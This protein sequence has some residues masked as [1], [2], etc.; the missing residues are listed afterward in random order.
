M[1][2]AL[3]QT[4]RDTS[5]LKHLLILTALNQS[6]ELFKLTEVVDL[7]T[8]VKNICLTSDYSRLQEGIESFNEHAEHLQE[9]C[10][11]LTHVAPTEHL[12]SMTKSSES[13]LC[14]YWPQV[15]NACQALCFHPMSKH[16]LTN[17]EVL[18]NLWLSLYNEIHHLSCA[19]SDLLNVSVS[20]I[21]SSSSLASLVPGR[22]S[23]FGHHPPLPP[24]S[25]ITHIPSS[26]PYHAKRVTIQDTPSEDPFGSIPSTGHA[27]P[28]HHHPL[29]PSPLVSS[30]GSYMRPPPSHLPPSSSYPLEQ[31]SVEEL[32]GETAAGGG[33][34]IPGEEASG[35]ASGQWP[36]SKDNDIIKRAKTMSSMAFSMYQFT[37]GLGELKTTQDLFTHAELFADEANMFYKLVRH[38]TYQVSLLFLL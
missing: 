21:A 4:V 3:L 15:I 37:Q 18:I 29:H 35:P 2:T 23:L 1:E 14:Q 33:S 25:G 24:S 38:F 26:S 11:L 32:T 28:S 31:E 6:D 8:R 30:S 9:V 19:V 13:S 17:L 16:A 22:R 5:E 27:I 7:L 36:D 12:E 34:V 20:A 10:K